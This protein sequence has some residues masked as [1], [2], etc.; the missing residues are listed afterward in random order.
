MGQRARIRFY[1]IAGGVI[2]LIIGLMYVLLFSPVFKVRAFNV[3]G[4]EHHSDREIMEIIS[5][6]VLNTKLKIFLGPN[7][8]LAWNISRP[9]ISKT[10]LA[11]A[12]V[13]RDW[14]RQ[15][16]NIKV[17]ERERLAIWCDKNNDCD[18]IDGSGMAIE[19]APQTEGSLI[20]AI[21]DSSASRIMLGERVL[22]NRFIGNLIS[23]I[24]GIA[25][26]KLPVK[27]ITY[28]ARLQEIRVE[29]YSG[30]ALFFST[31][32]DPVQNIASLLSLQEKI[33]TGRIGYV[34][35]RVEN[36]LYYK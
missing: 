3:S 7:N 34:D 31:R 9:D 5:P 8:L 1:F 16:I 25:T 24:K 17:R 32:F 29:N 19:K 26:M 35:L 20:I 22:G 11:E 33:D 18:W 13:E 10:A 6:L 12:A 21:Y 23:I 30:P 36:R 28:D 15:A 2:L 4:K 27:K 14:I